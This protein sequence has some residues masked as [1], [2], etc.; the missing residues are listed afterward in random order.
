MVGLK[1][2]L[3]GKRVDELEARCRAEGHG[4]RDRPIQLHDWRGHELGEGVVECGDALPIRF[5]RGARAS[6]TCH[7]GRLHRIGAR[8]A[9]K[10]LGTFECGESTMDEE[11]IPLRAVLI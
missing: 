1:R 2:G 11:L 7:D 5:R 3:R 8:R 9:A 6:V 4:E 10:L